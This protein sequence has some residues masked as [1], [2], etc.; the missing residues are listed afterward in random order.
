MNH[1]KKQ[2]SFGSKCHPTWLIPPSPKARLA[3]EAGRHHRRQHGPL[4]GE[5]GAGHGAGRAAGSC[6]FYGHY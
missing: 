4:H 1:K 6:E 2:S 5:G 3:D